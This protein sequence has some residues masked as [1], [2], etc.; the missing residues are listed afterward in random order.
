VVCLPGTHTKWVQIRAGKIVKFQTF[1]SG[2]LFDLLRLH[3]V[4][5]HSVE[6]TSWDQDAFTG[7]ITSAFANPQS[8]A[9]R[10][11]GVRADVLLSGLKPGAANARLSGALIGAELAAAR[12]FFER[13][14]V[15]IIGSRVQADIY[16][17]ALRALGKSSINIDAAGV[18]LAGLKSAY[19]KIQENRALRV[20]LLPFCAASGRRRRKLSVVP[21]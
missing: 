1:M 5:R 6:G 7:E 2:E 19:L 18:T 4:L 12:D 20:T 14:Q 16:T 15:V 17:D 10:L 8:L 11:F 21:S 13:Q 3:S 9:A